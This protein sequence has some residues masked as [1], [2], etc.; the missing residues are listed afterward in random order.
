MGQSTW[1]QE[2]TAISVE[3]GKGPAEALRAVRLPT[4]QPAE[5]QILI[6]VEA[7]GVNRPDIAQR[8]GFY[9]PP[10]GAPD[11]LGLEV[12]GEVLRGAGRWRPGDRVC[13][14]L[15]AAL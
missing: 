4:P 1:P 12:A 8:L 3:G 2:M 6:K 7:A 15:G 5:G 14:L 9:P 10:P 11:T 13:A